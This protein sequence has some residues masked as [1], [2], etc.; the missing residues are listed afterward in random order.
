MDE[1]RLHQKINREIADEFNVLNVHFAA[2]ANRPYPAGIFV[3]FFGND[4][5]AL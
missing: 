2:G 5:H 4:K 3:D 1:Y